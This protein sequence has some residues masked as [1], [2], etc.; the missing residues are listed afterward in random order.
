[1]TVWFTAD[2]HLGH[3]RI[4]EL[5]NRP[6]ASVAEMNETIIER[7]N[8]VVARTDMV[9]V[10]GDVALG[11]LSETLPLVRRLH[12]RKCLVPGNHDRCWSGHD[13]VSP[14]DL[15]RYT[16]VGFV[17]LPGHTFHRGLDAQLCHFPATVDVT[18]SAHGDDRFAAFRPVIRPGK[19]LV[20]G[21]VH[22]RWRVSDDQVNVGVDVWDFTPVSIETL[23][24]IRSG[25]I[26]WEDASEC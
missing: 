8:A 11:R 20:H 25:M 18:S 4:I 6:F 19:W 10:L 23:R 5:C 7:W 2:L 14:A 26:A 12:G 21:H 1:M 17:V 3:A 16:D 15:R 9:F 22:N 13:R 24:V